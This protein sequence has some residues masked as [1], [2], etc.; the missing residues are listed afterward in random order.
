MQRLIP[1]YFEMIQ[2]DFTDLQAFA[3]ED[4]CEP[5]QLAHLVVRKYLFDRKKKKEASEVKGA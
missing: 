4:L 5:R 1:I 2:D 3:L